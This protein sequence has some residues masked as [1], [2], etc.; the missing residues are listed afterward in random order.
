METDNSVKTIKD[1]K[2]PR[3]SGPHLVRIRLQRTDF[4]VSFSSLKSGNQCTNKSDVT[5][6]SW[7]NHVP[8]SA[9]VCDY[10]SLWTAA[11]VDGCCIPT[12]GCPRRV[13]SHLCNKRNSRCEFYVD[14]CQYVTLHCQIAEKQRNKLII[15]GPLQWRIYVNKLVCPI[16]GP[17]FFI[18]SRAVALVF[19][20]K[21]FGDWSLVRTMR[22]RHADDLR[23]TCRWPADDTRVR[24]RVRF[25]WQMTCHQDVIRTLAW[26]AHFMQYYTWCH[27]HVI[28]S[29]RN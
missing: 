3:Y 18:F 28:H 8:C 22:I 25:H 2:R 7:A 29:Q 23:M 6:L 1:T 4:V 9:S 16:L 19:N 5:W 12:S 20:W 15:K 24:F 26:V 11:P 17:I 14:S 13:S 27:P 10:I 21:Y